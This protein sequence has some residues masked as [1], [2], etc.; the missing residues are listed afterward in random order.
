MGAIKPLRVIVAD[1]DRATTDAL[2]WLL[3]LAGHAVVGC[4]AGQD[5]IDQAL[6]H[7]AEAA[8]LDVEL[9]E[10]NGYEVARQ[11]RHSAVCKE[12]LLVAITG[13]A[14]DEHRQLAMQVGFDHYF[15]KP[16]DFAILH[17]MLMNYGR[18]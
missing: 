5:A 12:T 15:V 17:Q 16:V 9:P 18:K 6:A 13:F 4:Y 1:D 3:Q 10:L 8:I 2:V 11:L 14:D 7:Q